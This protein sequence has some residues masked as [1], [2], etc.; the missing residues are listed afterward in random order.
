MSC[1][2]HEHAFAYQ[3]TVCWYGN[4][5]TPGGGAYPRHYADAYYCQSC[6]EIKL[7]NERQDGNSYEK[8]KFDATE[9]KGKPA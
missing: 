9:Y 6:L 4:T 1:Q 7:R 2:T 8:V 5:P 3:G